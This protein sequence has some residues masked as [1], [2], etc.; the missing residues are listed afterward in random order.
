MKVKAVDNI[1][2]V[3]QVPEEDG[4]GGFR[5]RSEVTDYKA[6]EVYDLADPIAK[7]L[8]TAGYVSEDLDAPIKDHLLPAKGEVAESAS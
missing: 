8:L 7:K 1:H 3:R 5:L 2:F 6:G 4:E